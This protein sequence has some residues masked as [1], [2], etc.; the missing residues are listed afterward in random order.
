[1]TPDIDFNRHTKGIKVADGDNRLHEKIILEGTS[2]IDFK[3]SGSDTGGQLAI[4][5][6]SNNL[7]GIAAPALHLHPDLDETFFVLEGTFKF[8]VGDELFYLKVGD[9]MFI[10]RNVAHAFICISDIPGK[11][12]IVVQ[13]AGKLEDF[14]RAWSKFDK[15]TPEIAMQLMK[16]NNMEVVGPPLMVD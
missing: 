13:P 11:L 14:F 2:P 6:S 5:T 3:V 15:V 7:K 4:C 12:L 9:S 16:E 10:P 1:M 8:K